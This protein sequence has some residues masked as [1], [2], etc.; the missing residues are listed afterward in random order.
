[1]FSFSILKRGRIFFFFTNARFYRLWTTMWHL[2]LLKN[3]C[4]NFISI[5]CIFTVTKNLPWNFSIN[6]KAVATCYLKLTWLIFYISR[7]LTMKCSKQAPD[8]RL[9]WPESG[10]CRTLMKDE[11]IVPF[12][13]IDNMKLFYHYYWIGFLNRQSWWSF[14]GIA[15]W[16]SNDK[17]KLLDRLKF[18]GFVFQNKIKNTSD[19][20][21]S[22]IFKFKSLRRSSMSDKKREK[23]GFLN[24]KES[25]L[26]ASINI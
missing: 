12:T 3:K 11:K 5:F 15:K 17:G 6:L 7:N 18:K 26:A 13:G 20:M 9:R 24:I 21:I 1:M 16:I 10:V 19:Y 14:T 2:T 23:S 4:E 25:H 22:L 8:Q